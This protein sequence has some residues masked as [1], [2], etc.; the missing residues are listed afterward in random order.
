MSPSFDLG[1]LTGPVLIFGGPYSNAQ[2]TVAIRAEAERRGIPSMNCLCTGDVVAYCADPQFTV[3]EI[4][5]WGVSVVMGNC[6]Q[7]LALNS[8]ECGCGFKKGSAC[9]ILSKQW[10]A[11]S[12]ASITADIR[13]WM[14]EL[15]QSIRFELGGKQVVAFHGAIDDISGFIFAS[16]SESVKRQQAGTAHAD[17]IL[18]GHCGLPFTQTLKNGAIWHNSGVVGMP[19]N[20]GTADVWYSVLTPCL[21]GVDINHHRLAYDYQK[22]ASRIRE[23]NLSEDYALALENGLW[24]SLDILPPQEQAASGIKIQLR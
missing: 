14:A 19:A 20:D 3:D 8:N 24:P 23:E 12:S 16:T 15:P 17:I 7:S 1:E 2:A 21:T 6:E 11:Y 4:R 5:D 13:V 18:A 22:A 10:F 9:D